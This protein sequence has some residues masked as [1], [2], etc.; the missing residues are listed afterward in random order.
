MGNDTAS[1]GE[2]A[3]RSDVGFVDLQ[4]VDIL[5]MVKSVTIP[6]EQLK[7][8]ENHRQWFDGS[9]IQGFS[10][11]S[12]NDMYLEP[13]AGTF[14]VLPWLRNG[15]RVARV[16]CDV[17]TP[18]KEPFD[19]DPR[20]LLRNVLHDAAER[21]YG[22]QVSP[23]MEFFL[24]DSI[25]PNEIP[26][27]SD[28]GSYFDL[29]KD[30]GHDIRQQMVI[31]L[32]AMGI[33]VEAGHHE[34]AP[35][36][37]EIDCRMKPGLVSA[38]NIVTLKWV[39]REVAKQHSLFA[40]FMPKPLT[41]AFGSGMHL[42]QILTDIKNGSNL[43]YSDEDPYKLSKLG[44]YFVAGQIE[45]A[46][47]MCAIIA[48]LVNSYKRLVAGYEAPTVINWARENRSAFIRLPET[49]EDEPEATRVEL[50]APDPSCNP[51]LAIAVM[52]GAGLDGIE[53]ELPLP[54]AVEETI[55]AIEPAHNR[56]YHTGILPEN[57]KEALDE[58]QTDDVICDI[59]GPHLL[60]QFLDAKRM[61]WEDYRIQVS[62]WELGHYLTSY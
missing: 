27:S 38:D 56:K 1:I 5:G 16:I 11:T 17:L 44:R 10:R 55:L 57:L 54:E 8:V 39:I 40:S 33:E 26:V 51:Y 15:Q 19:G 21:G 37:Q 36:Q 52:L 50:R 34:V 59:L 14:V 3:Q 45:H 22:F 58:L 20:Y 9:S 31:Q 62:A 12:E 7:R 25:K 53:R 43:F 6:I 60:Q 41:G 49:T 23:E 61:E 18:K 2:Q 47:G 29:S 48:P 42:H 13:D 4:F 24:F 28:S 32:E 35:G 46:R 30:A